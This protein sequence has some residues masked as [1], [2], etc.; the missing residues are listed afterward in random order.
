MLLRLVPELRAY[1]AYLED[2]V[3]VDVGITQ[4]GSHHFVV[5]C[6]RLHV[7]FSPDVRPGKTSG[8]PRYLLFLLVLQPFCKPVRVRE[9]AFTFAS[10]CKVA[11]DFVGVSTAFVA[12]YPR[13]LCITRHPYAMPSSF[14]GWD[15]IFV[16]SRFPLLSVVQVDNI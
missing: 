9:G 6:V 16:V 8:T 1:G 11:D 15:L 12:P 5:W 4:A 2:P 10:V 3:R 7:R 13:L 14:F